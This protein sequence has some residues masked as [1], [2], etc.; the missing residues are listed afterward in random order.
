MCFYSQ[1]NL[2][3]HPRSRRLA[4]K[5]RT[6]PAK[7]AGPPPQPQARTQ[8]PHAGKKL[9]WPG[10]RPPVITTVDHHNRSQGS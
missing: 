5:I 1:P 8:N 2:P 10:S 9:P 6:K 3:A 4:R 7:S